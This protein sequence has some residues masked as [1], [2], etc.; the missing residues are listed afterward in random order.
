MKRTR[1]STKDGA[2]P[3]TSAKKV[4]S[5]TVTNVNKAVDTTTTQPKSKKLVKM[6]QK[7]GKAANKTSITKSTKKNAS[8]KPK[9]II[10]SNSKPIEA[11]TGSSAERS[12]VNTRS[13]IDKQS[14]KQMYQEHAHFTENDQQFSMV[15]SANEAPLAGNF[16]DSDEEIDFPLQGHSHRGEMSSQSEANCESD[17]CPSTDPDEDDDDYSDGGNDSDSV[18]IRPLTKA[19]RIRQMEELDNEMTEKLTELRDLMESGGMTKATKF[20]QENFLGSPVAQ[21]KPKATPSKGTQQ[22]HQ[23]KETLSGNWY[24]NYFGEVVG[25]NYNENHGLAILNSPIHSKSVETIYRNAVKKRMSSSSEEGINISDKTMNLITDEEAFQPDY[26]DVAMG[27]PQQTLQMD[28]VQPGLS[29]DREPLA[30]N[31]RPGDLPPEISQLTPEQ[32]A[33]KLVIDAENAKAHIFPNPGNVANQLT[34][35]RVSNTPTIAAM[36]EDYL[37]IGVHVDDTM[38]G[39]IIK[40]EYIDFGKLLPHDR[41]LSEEDNRLELVIKN[42]KTYWMPIAETTAINNFSRWEQ[43][44]RIYSNIYTRQ[45][46]HRSSELIQYNHIIHTIAGIYTWDNVYSYDKEFRLHLSKHPA[47]SWSVILQQAWSMK[48]CDRINR[49]DSHAQN[50]GG[51]YQGKSDSRQRQHSLI[52]EPCKRFNPGKCPFV[53]KC[54]YEHQCAYEPCG[55]FGHSILNCRKLLA[56]REKTNMKRDTTVAVVQPKD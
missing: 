1:S 2:I 46:P 44:F 27:E 6:V 23:Q 30:S 51:G 11:A 28:D 50:S 8:I 17:N 10:S 3:S 15:V 24:G 55:K 31:S 43:T 56:D 38:Q 54:K 42:G 35:N 40:G 13:T 29:R 36:D 52:P 16:D 39:K 12:N 53:P 26:E 32:K 5:S 22:R 9:K 4:G 34:F 41:I 18:K 33:E 21:M 37:V 20:M 45:F 25:K 47:R 19:D 14:Q 48:L 7:V 49:S